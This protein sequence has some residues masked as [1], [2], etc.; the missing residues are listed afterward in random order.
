L[1]VVTLKVFPPFVLDGNK[2]IERKYIMADDA[3]L[4]DLLMMAKDDVLILNKVISL[5]SQEIREG[6]VVLVN[7]RT[8][9][10]INYILSNGDRVAILPLAPGG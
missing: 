5:E 6:V 10:D 1:K 2:S 9:F 8:V 4:I 3:R 7:G